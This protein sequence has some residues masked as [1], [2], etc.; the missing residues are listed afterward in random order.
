MR[1]FL[2]AMLASGHTYHSSIAQLDFI[3]SKKTIEAIIW[4]HTEDI[5]QAF[6]AVF[7]AKQGDQLYAFGAPEQLRSRSAIR[8]ATGVIGNEANAFSF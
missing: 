2:V 8:R 1:L 6:K 4:L 7:G 3:S 5:E